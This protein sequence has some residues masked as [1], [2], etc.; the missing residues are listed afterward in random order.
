LGDISR[1]SK[2]EQ[3]MSYLGLVS[4]EDSSGKRRRQGGITKAGNDDVIPF[5]NGGPHE[6]G[7]LFRNWHVTATQADAAGGVSWIR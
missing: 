4:S 2:A 3:F 6:T 7:A 5:A 1:F